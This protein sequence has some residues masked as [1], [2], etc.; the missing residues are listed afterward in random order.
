MKVPYFPRHK[1]KEPLK[2][3]IRLATPEDLER[4]GRVAK[5][6]EET[7]QIAARLS[8]ERELPMKI[9]QVRSSGDGNKLTI[10]FT[11][12][13]RVDFRE[14]VRD[15]SHRLRAKIEMKQIGVRDEAA[16]AGAGLGSC[17]RTL[18]CKSWL[19]RFHPVT[20]KMAKE[21]KL[22]L[23]STKITG[24]CGR[25]KCC[26]AYEYPIYRDLL[27]RLPKVGQPVDTPQGPGIVQ[28]QDLLHEAV[29]VELEAGGRLRVTLGEI[30]QI[31]AARYDERGGGHPC[32]KCGDGAGCGGR[33]CEG[34]CANGGCRAKSN[35][36]DERRR[37]GQG[38]GS[39]E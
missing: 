14:L 25:L 30:M 26:V 8:Q 6:E 24:V 34:G 31:A 5:R 2:P 32:N 37:E 3:V 20:M 16:I 11:A 15:L 10:F 27:R 12:E 22:S 23:N 38:S 35:G 9:V 18:C 19:P 28:A 17:G 13:E 21:Q 36:D 29:M 39:N 33:G 7:R 4:I 1:L